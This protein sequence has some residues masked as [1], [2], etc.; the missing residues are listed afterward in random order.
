M[1][2]LPSYVE[3]GGNRKNKEEKNVAFEIMRIQKMVQA[4]NA[5]EIK[6]QKEHKITV[7]GTRANKG[8][9]VEQAGL[10]LVFKK[11]HFQ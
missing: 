9:S 4:P 5:D 8:K 10:N 7:T 3:T 6:R 1:V 11:M 2:L